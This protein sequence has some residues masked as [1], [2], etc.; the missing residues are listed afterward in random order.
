MIRLLYDRG[1]IVETSPDLGSTM[2][3]GKREGLLW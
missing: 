3:L 2:H 1:R